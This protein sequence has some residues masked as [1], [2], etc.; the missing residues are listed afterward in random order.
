MRLSADAD[1]RVSVAGRLP[2]GFRRPRVTR[3]P[4]RAGGSDPWPKTSLLR[5]RHLAG[6]G[7]E[8]LHRY[9][10]DDRRALV[11]GDVA[12]R[13][14]V[15]QLHRLRLLR[16]HP[17]RLQQFLGCLQLALGVD[18]LGATLALGLGLAGDRAHHGFI[19]VDLLD[20]DR[21]DLDA[22]GIGLRVEHLL[23]GEVQLFAL[24]EQLVQRVLAQHRAQRSLREIA[25]RGIVLLDLDHRLG[26]IDDAKVNDRIDFYR[27]VVARDHVLWRYIHHDRTQIDAHPLL[28]PWND[29]DQPGALDF[30]EA[31]EH[32]HHA[33]L[34]FAQNLEGREDQQDDNDDET[35]ESHPENHF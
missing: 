17:R 35:A 20:F 19:E 21:R 34:V 28:D 4:C 1:G 31:A 24:G 11:T 2:A 32:E 18:D 33:A 8:K 29:E 14:Q 26:R 27:D 7:G 15:A 13:L 10:E 25:R 22:P 3:S 23:D 12:E 9:R 16:E 5:L 30:P 6:E